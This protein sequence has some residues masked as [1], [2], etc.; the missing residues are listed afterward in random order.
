LSLHQDGSLNNLNGG[1][2]ISRVIID[3][4]KIEASG[5]AKEI[6][7]TI[8]GL[9]P[10]HVKSVIFA[11]VC[12]YSEKMIVQYPYS[13]RTAKDEGRCPYYANGE[14]WSSWEYR[15]PLLLNKK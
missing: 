15:P 9:T 8:V 12:D 3:H 13:I 4:A 2:C 11:Y 1:P 7:G 6:G 10:N 5:Q 14:H